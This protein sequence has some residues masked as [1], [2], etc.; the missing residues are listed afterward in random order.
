M[1]TATYYVYILQCADKTLYTGITTDLQRR[2]LE[3]K[4]GTGAHYTKT[5]G[6]KKIVYSE[7]AP[8]RSVASQRE[9]SIKKLSRQE[10]LA[11]IQSKKLRRSSHS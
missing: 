10:K 11:L 1:K 2:L 7:T 4:N 8:N 5:R 9:H 3:H 6:A